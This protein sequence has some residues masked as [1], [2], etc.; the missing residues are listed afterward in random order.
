MFI[1]FFQISKTI[2]ILKSMKSFT[3]MNYNT[4]GYGNTKG[5]TQ[6]FLEK[7]PENFLSQLPALN[8]IF[9]FKTSLSETF[10]QSYE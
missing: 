10:C 1:Y 9:S 5:L 2:K 6:S 8:L 7:G 3:R 4:K